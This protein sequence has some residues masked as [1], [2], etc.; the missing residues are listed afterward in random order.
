ML[1]RVHW[2]AAA[3]SGALAHWC[4]PLH[5]L[6]QLQR[7]QCG[8]KVSD[9][10]HYAHLHSH[11]LAPGWCV[12]SPLAGPHIRGRRRFWATSCDRRARSR[13]QRRSPHAGNRGSAQPEEGAGRE[14]SVRISIKG[15]RT[16]ACAY[17]IHHAHATRCDSKLLLDAS[18]RLCCHPLVGVPP[19]SA[20][21]CTIAMPLGVTCQ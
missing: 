9:Q 8:T 11:A 14:G 1:P 12:T 7:H 20:T 5:R 18:T 6:C 13:V 19:L 15:S 17:S 4:C 3:G 10:Q 16:V 21:L 2:M